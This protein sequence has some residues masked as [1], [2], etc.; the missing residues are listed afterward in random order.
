MSEHEFPE[1]GR[2]RKR[3]VVVDAVRWVW[4]NWNA[5]CDFAPVPDVVYVPEEEKTKEKPSLRV[6][7]LEGE[8]VCHYGD[9]IVRGVAGEFYPVRDD[10]FQQTYEPASS[11]TALDDA[12]DIIA[13]LVARHCERD[14]I[15]DSM[16]SATYAEAIEFLANT[17]RVRIT[18]RDGN[19][20]IAEWVIRGGP[21][22][23]GSENDT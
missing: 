5:I 17:G 16:Y 2:Y 22:K 11:R 3:S 19:S 4:P 6:R 8:M 15:L 7:T 23:E 18:R 20:I 13:D 10:I 12:V 21:Y 14:G 1:A 9:W